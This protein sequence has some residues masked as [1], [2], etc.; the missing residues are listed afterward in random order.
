[1]TSADW[2]ALKQ[3]GN[4]HFKQQENLKAAAAYTEAIKAFSGD[5]KDLAVL[6]RC[7]LPPVET[8]PCLSRAAHIL[9]VAMLTSASRCTM[10]SVS[11][12]CDPV[13][14]PSSGAAAAVNSRQARQSTSY[15]F[16]A[17]HPRT[18]AP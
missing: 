1:M 18:V 10:L 6:Y 16:P 9:L 17:A 15:E 7:V 3:K 13:T 5:D 8:V 14:M 12:C 2:Q 11:L 4:D